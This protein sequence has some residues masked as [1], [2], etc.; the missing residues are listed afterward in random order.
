MD[1]MKRKCPGHNLILRQR[2]AC[3]KCLASSRAAAV[4]KGQR[5]RSA[6]P[7]RRDAPYM[8]LRHGFWRGA[9]G[10]LDPVQCPHSV[11]YVPEIGVCLGCGLE[12]REL[13]LQG[14]ART[15]YV[16]QG[17]DS[18]AYYLRVPESYDENT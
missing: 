5:A 3:P 1:L 13:V 11:H 6:D 15:A 8:G 17:H 7:E 2:E 14:Y 18:A 4:A 16:L 12:A 9:A 10:M